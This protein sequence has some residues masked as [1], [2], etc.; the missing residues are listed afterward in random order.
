M[1]GK[2]DCSQ[3][4]HCG[5]TTNQKGCNIQ[6]VMK[7]VFNAKLITPCTNRANIKTTKAY[8]ITTFIQFY[9]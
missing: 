3:H 7:R 2:I 5:A 6:G 9:S 8:I 1:C 4:K